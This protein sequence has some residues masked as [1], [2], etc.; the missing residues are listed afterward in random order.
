MKTFNRK[1][2][3]GRLSRKL[4][5]A[6]LLLGFFQGIDQAVYAGETADSSRGEEVVSADNQD[7]KSDENKV[8][9]SV[10]VNCLS[11]HAACEESKKV[12][13][14]LMQVSKTYSQ[15]DFAGFEKHL[16][17]EVTIFDDSSKKLIVGKKDVMAYVKK[18]WKDAHKGPNPVV[19]YTIEHPYAKV[20]GDTAVVTFKAI[21]VIGGAE[22][23]GTYVS[24]STD[25]FVK[26]NGEW[27]KLH[28][29]SH[30]KKVKS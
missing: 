5:V 22:K 20:T 2:V 30:W 23:A 16:D 12:I 11:P 8:C 26:R 1:R 18:R 13:D 27:K 28:Y 19:S 21:K 17:D 15:G 25:V 3:T 29:V 6:F 24:K 4:L 10:P 9:S 7:K 14:T